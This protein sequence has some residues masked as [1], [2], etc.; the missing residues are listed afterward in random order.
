MGK[1]GT[2]GGSRGGDGAGLRLRLA[3]AAV[4]ALAVVPVRSHAGGGV[5]AG[6]GERSAASCYQAL[7]ELGVAYAKKKEKGVALAVEV[8]GPLGGVSY[9]AYNGKPL[10]IDC[11]LVVSLALSGPFLAEEGID[12]VTF[13]SATQRR[14]IRGT[15]RPSNHSFGLALDI[16]TF[17]GDDLDLVVRDDYEQGFGDEVDCIGMTYTDAGRALRTMMCQF[18]RSGLFRS[19]LSPDYDDDHYN[20][21]HLD[22]LPWAERRD[23][24]S[25]DAL[26]RR[27]S[28]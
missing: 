6:G 11:S 12:K 19:V 10:V 16:H 7:D 8:R 22:V 13:S 26:A 1:L 3:V 25:A 24:R 27:A 15:S 23:E 9:R 5:A 2:I 21:F 18:T 14:N 20:H 28:K 17:S 4:L